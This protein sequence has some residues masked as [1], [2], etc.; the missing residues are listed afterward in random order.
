M[1]DR[2]PTAPF[3]VLSAGQV[4]IQRM[5]K[6]DVAE[7]RAEADDA[8]HLASTLDDPVSVADLVEYA[9]SLEADANRWEARAFFSS[10]Q[11]HF[12]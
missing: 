7:L 10:L 11:A 4:M 1:I 6:E 3:D 2:I 8:R 5:T 9:V 12:G